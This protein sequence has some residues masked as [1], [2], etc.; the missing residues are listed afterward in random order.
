MQCLAGASL[1]LK[2]ISSVFPDPM[3]SFVTIVK[4][5]LN[6]LSMYEVCSYLFNGPELNET[7]KTNKSCHW[8]IYLGVSWTL[9]T[10]HLFLIIFPFIKVEGFQ[11]IFLTCRCQP[12]PTHNVHWQCF[13]SAQLSSLWFQKVMSKEWLPCI[14]TLNLKSKQ[15][16]QSAWLHEYFWLCCNLPRY[17]TMLP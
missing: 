11:L 10:S 9:S 1:I 3:C 13:C 2:R 17:F 12:T 14:N 8:Q 15:H 5:E 7:R 4:R 6:K 16:H